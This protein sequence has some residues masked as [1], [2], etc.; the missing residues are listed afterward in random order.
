MAL[1]MNA[2]PQAKKMLVF[3]V[4][5]VLNLKSWV[6]EISNEVKCLICFSN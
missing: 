5:M 3:G 6:D 1:S 2:T 4:K